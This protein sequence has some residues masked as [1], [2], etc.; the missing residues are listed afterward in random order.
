MKKIFLFLFVVLSFAAVG[1]V[2][3]T[4]KYQAVVRDYAGDVQ[5]DKIVS[6]RISILADDPNGANLYTETQQLATNPFGVANL[7]IGGGQQVSGNFTT[8]DWST[9][10]FFVKIEL[11]LNGG[12]NFQFMGT[13]QL[14][15]VPLSFYSKEAGR[16]LN[17]MDT[18]ATN[19]I[20]DL[21][22]TGNSLE[23]TGN[24]NPNPIDLAPYLDNTDSQTLDLNGTTLSISNGNSVQ[25]TPDDDHDPLN[26]IQTVSQTG[27]DVTLSNNG[28][29]FSVADNDNDPANELQTISK[30][31]NQVTL[32]QS[33]GNF[34]DDID[35]ADH[36]PANELQ[37]ISKVGN[38]I[39]LDQNGGSVTDS[40]NQQLVLNG[41]QLSITDGNA[42]TLA[43]A[44]D[45]DPDPTNELQ[46]ISKTGNT[47]TLTQ[48]GGNFT[49]SDNQNLMSSANGTQ[50]TIDISDGTG[51]IFDIADNDND[52][53]NEFQTLSTSNDTLSISNGNSIV[54][55][56]ADIMPPGT[57]IN[58][59]DPNPPSGFAYSGDYFITEDNAWSTFAYYS[60]VGAGIGGFVEQNGLFY[61]FYLVGGSPQTPYTIEIN[62]TTNVTT[63]KTPIPMYSTYGTFIAF[64]G[65]IYYISSSSM[66]EYDPVADNWTSK[67]ILPNYSMANNII[68]NS[69]YIFS[70]P[71][72]GSSFYKY[73][74]L[75]NSWTPISST[76]ARSD[77]KVIVHNEKLYYVGG[78][79]G[80]LWA[81]NVQEYNPQTNTW[82]T[83]AAM[84]F[85]T[86]E[87][88]IKLINDKI[89]CIG[90]N[91]TVNV[92]GDLDYT[93]EYNIITDTWS[94]KTPLPV[95]DENM[96]S[97]VH[98]Q[99]IYVQGSATQGR[100][101]YKYDTTNDTYFTMIPLSS[102]YA[103][104][105]YSNSYALKHNNTVFYLANPTYKYNIENEQK[106]YY[107]HCK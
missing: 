67:N 29:S 7:N 85:P 5:A 8:I 19:E 107:M 100:Y 92:G 53:T 58:S 96:F 99:Y 63:Q 77:A 49:D 18:S 6:F 31:G 26:E 55:S 66:Y 44:V 20:Q 45:L 25:L 46:N 22:L 52:S 94:V 1:Q 106:I 37:T 33:G 2:P 74:P 36:D 51:T 65:K 28:G 39:T 17:D 57:C 102:E 35:D 10:V 38:T 87:F 27:L 61:C 101:N 56:L 75:L 13:S 78:K 91:G 14:M 48:N 32:S 59:L 68:A 34:T 93:Q 105:F 69:L 88:E 21:Q 60:P 80:T 72:S 81:P 40:D 103:Y 79:I 84:P 89:Y 71:T 62:P 70:F 83:K 50:R 12:S 98:G 95:P 54:L 73:D 90:G 23:I 64:Q 15:T 47:V 24:P 16:S 4:I 30:V 104:G 76:T 3:N 97:F 11:D 42:I 43:G 9:S 41:N 82:T 86:K